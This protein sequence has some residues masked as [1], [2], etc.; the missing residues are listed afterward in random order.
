MRLAILDDQTLLRDG[1]KQIL[2]IQ[3]IF[4]S[5]KTYGSYEIEKLKDDIPDFLIIDLSVQTQRVFDLMEFF[6]SRN[7]SV[8]VFTN[9]V[10][11][12]IVLKSIRHGIS[13]Y[14]LKSMRT[15]ELLYGMSVILK[16]CTFFHHQ[17][18]DLLLKEYMEVSG[19]ENKSKL[20]QMK[21]RPLGLLTNREWEVLDLLA[22]GYNNT[23]LSEE[24]GISDKT[25]KVHVAN[26]LKKLKVSDRTTAVIIAVK[27]GW[28]TLPNECE[29]DK[30]FNN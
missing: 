23:I 28:T 7:V 14:M 5:I 18:S 24:L 29:L 27:R 25:A 12:S 9:E 10:N 6:I 8:V 20:V 22:K 15:K 19:L 3:N 4:H 21:K 2:S 30:L 26:I 16:G 17:I 13:G 11:P 1:L